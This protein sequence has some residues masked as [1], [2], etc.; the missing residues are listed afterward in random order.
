VLPAFMAI[1]AG[2]ALHANYAGI[3]A[4]EEQVEALQRLYFEKQDELRQCFEQLQ[5]YIDQDN[6]REP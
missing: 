1:L 3:V 4:R 5:F 2:F 6:G